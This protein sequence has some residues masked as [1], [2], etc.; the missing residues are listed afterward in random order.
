V[1]KK[2]FAC[3]APVRRLRPKLMTVCAVLASVIPILWA[4]GIGSDEAVY[5]SRGRRNDYVH[6]SRTDSGSGVV[7]I[8]K[9]CRCA[10]S[11]PACALPGTD[12][13]NPVGI[14]PEWSTT[15]TLPGLG[16]GCPSYTT[17]G[18]W[19]LISDRNTWLVRWSAALWLSR[20]PCANERLS[21]PW[22]HL[23]AVA[24]SQAYTLGEDL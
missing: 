1:V 3:E 12:K 15:L 24:V 9:S 17:K 13:R 7:R 16:K 19:P 11:S 4:S 21:F 2:R 22:N 8:D 20:S 14:A 18:Q 10:D 5:S 6:D 23:A